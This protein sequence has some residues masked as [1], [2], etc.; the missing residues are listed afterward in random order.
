MLFLKLNFNCLKCNFSLT[1]SLKPL[2]LLL[3]RNLNVR[4]AEYR[5]QEGEGLHTAPLTRQRKIPPNNAPFAET[6]REWDRKVYMPKGAN[7]RRFYCAY[8]KK[9][10]WGGGGGVISKCFISI[11]R[12]PRRNAN[13][14]CRVTLW[15]A[16]WILAY[17]KKI[18]LAV[19]GDS[20]SSD[21]THLSKSLI[22]IRSVQIQIR[23]FS[24]SRRN[25]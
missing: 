2:S 5:S 11:A 8:R 24:I 12:D 16:N 10:H 14:L 1:L 25:A 3:R 15:I 7:F 20:Y 17:S 9:R 23:A 13:S 6:I 19:V 22:R 4:V 21:R 18:T